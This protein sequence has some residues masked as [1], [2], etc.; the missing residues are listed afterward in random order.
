M[1]LAVVGLCCLAVGCM[2]QQPAS[3]ADSESAQP[4]WPSF[5]KSPSP[6]ASQAD[7]ADFFITCS[8]ALAE[9]TLAG[10]ILTGKEDA[11]LKQVGQTY[12]T[13]GQAYSSK[14]YAMNELQQLH[15]ASVTRIKGYGSGG[16][17]ALNMAVMLKKDQAQETECANYVREHKTQV[18][19]QARA[20]GLMTGT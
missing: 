11:N 15:S 8:S 2:A 3:A 19:A 4:T 1:K 7:I 5:L 9:S 10:A 17:F 18:E 12:F 16:T 20:S 14:Q 6:S 13:L